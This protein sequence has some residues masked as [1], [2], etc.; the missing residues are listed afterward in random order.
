MRKT[1]ML[2]TMV[3]LSISACN[4]HPI[5]QKKWQSMIKAGETEYNQKNYKKAEKYLNEALKYANRLGKYGESRYTTLSTLSAVYL[6]QGEYEKAAEATKEALANIDAVPALSGLPKGQLMERLAI[7]YSMLAEVRLKEKNYT[8]AERLCGEATN[9]IENTDENRQG[10][11]FYLARCYSIQSES[12]LERERPDQ[13]AKLLQKALDI[14][15]ETPDTN[16]LD[17][18]NTINSLAYAWEINGSYFQSETLYRRALKI[19][20]K[21]IGPECPEVATCLDNLGKLLSDIGRKK[22]ADKVRAQANA[23]REKLKMLPEK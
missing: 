5:A 10:M 8:E 18:A 19:Y 14:Q 23:I 7:C 16:P 12:L 9:M 17:L 6:E 1:L 15:E 2:I 3:I 21:E 4:Y 22:E 13:A 11:A 20:K